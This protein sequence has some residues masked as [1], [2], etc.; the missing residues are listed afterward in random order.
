M[1]ECLLTVTTKGLHT[2]Q[3]EI[4]FKQHEDYRVMVMI[5]YGDV[6]SLADTDWCFLLGDWQ[7]RILKG[8]DVLALQSPGIDHIF[9]TSDDVICIKHMNPEQ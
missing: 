8:V 3:V 6:T 4:C 9:D 1:M 7:L 2:I 5:L